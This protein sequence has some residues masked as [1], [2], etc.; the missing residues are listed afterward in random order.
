VERIMHPFGYVGIDFGTSNSHFAYCNVEGDLKPQTI[1]LAG[2]SSVTTCV[3]WRRLAQE[4]HDI[5]AY[6]A[7]TVEAW[8]GFEAHERADCHFAFG[9]K[10]DLIH[11]ERARRD[12][13]A[14]LLKTR[15]EVQRAGLPRPLGPAGMAVV[16]GVPAEV[17]AEHRRWT[18]EA[19]RAAGFGDAECLEEPLG[20]LAFHLSAGD[21]TPTEA[22]AGVVVVDFGGGTLDV[23]LV[24]AA[25]LREPWGDS[26][27]GGRLFDDLF[28]QWLCDQNPGLAIDDPE[29]L[30]VWQ[31]ECRELKERNEIPREVSRY[32]P[33]STTLQGLRA[34]DGRVADKITA[35]LGELAVMAATVTTSI[36]TLVVTVV[37]VKLIIV[38]AIAHPILALLAAAGALLAWLGIK[39]ATKDV[40]E[41]TIRNH[42]FNAV[43]LPIL[44]ACLWESECWPFPGLRERLAAGRA[45]AAT[46]LQA[47]LR[48][49][50]R[51][52]ED[53]AAAKFDAII[54]L[55]IQDLGVLEWFRPAAH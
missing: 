13:W 51:P 15:Q 46:K 28:F 49:N 45:D 43:T 25:G 42:E 32:I 23:A 44:Q 31:R 29:A 52:L 16:V 7:E 5:L 17:G 38:L 36:V 1:Q 39:N 54:D 27:L 50:V 34:G 41:N 6:G 21:V 11:S 26:V 3:W 48:A 53:A 4:E 24:S 10:P 2:K 9:F 18:A 8:T 35:E 55:V 40:V 47:E 12:A 19:A 20:A 37:K 14:F 22:R 30:V 33:E